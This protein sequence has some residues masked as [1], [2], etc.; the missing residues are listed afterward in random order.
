M[1]PIALSA[2]WFA[3]T[4]GF[5]V[6]DVK[7]IVLEDAR[8]MREDGAE[9]IELPVPLMG[10]SLDS[11]DDAF[12]ADLGNEIRALGLV[13]L[14]VHG[15]NWPG[16]DA[17]RQQTRTMLKRYARLSAALKVRALVAHPTAH[18]HPHVCDVVPRLIERDLE[19]A[20][21]ISDELG[22]SGTMLAIENLPTYGIR[23]LMELMDRLPQGNIGVC[24]DTGHWNV[25][26]EFSI[27]D[28]LA[29]LGTRI[30]HMHL[31]DNSGLC[32]QH[33][34]PGAGNFDWDRFYQAAPAKWRG[35]MSL[36]ELSPPLLMN[37]L[38]AVSKTR[39]H[40]RW[41]ISTAKQTLETSCNHSVPGIAGR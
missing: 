24:F 22:D 23:Y 33:L 16:L 18:S 11:L 19:M 36:V 9:G 20:R 1:P 12:F 30:C 32:D 15:P 7:R 2:N 25:R 28:V 29:R 41:A 4:T 3:H 8:L 34:P 38:D 5:S 13:T 10:G 35:A 31:S 6:K 26:P 27:Q 39:V 14:S 21:L 40:H 17:D 37:D